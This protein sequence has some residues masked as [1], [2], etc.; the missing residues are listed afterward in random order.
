VYTTA[1]DHVAEWAPPIP[2]ATITFPANN[3]WTNKV[4]FAGKSNQ[5][6]ALTCTIFGPANR[7]GG[8]LYEIRPTVSSCADLNRRRLV[9]YASYQLTVQATNTEG[10]SSREHTRVFVLDTDKPRTSVTKVS[11]SSKKISGKVVYTTATPKLYFSSAE[12][13]FEHE[14]EGYNG[15]SAYPG[16]GGTH[17]P[18]LTY[19]YTCQVDSQKSTSCRSPFSTPTLA[20]G[21][22]TIAVRARDQAGNRFTLDYRIVVDAPASSCS[23]RLCIVP[24]HR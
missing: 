21:T 2:T 24:I 1:R 15:D 4:R 17:V 16:Y 19:T 3:A 20:N 13:R 23:A 18:K 8:S 12:S 9:D 5:P 7:T 14:F 22:H 11:G 10:Y 6:G